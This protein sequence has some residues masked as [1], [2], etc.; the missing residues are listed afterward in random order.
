MHAGA[1]F[2]GSANLGVAHMTALM[3]FRS[4]AHLSHLRRCGG[5]KGDCGER[6]HFEDVV[7]MSLKMFKTLP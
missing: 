5:E 7:R 4:T 6:S 2:E 1:R 3:G